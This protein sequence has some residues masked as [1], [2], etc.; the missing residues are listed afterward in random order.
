MSTSA[1]ENPLTFRLYQSVKFNRPIDKEKDFISPGGYELKMKD[2]DGTEKTVQFDFEDF[3][4]GVN[5]NDPCVL[6]C[7]QKNPDYNTFP[8]LKT[9]TKHMLQNVTE[10]VEWFIYTGEPEDT[11]LLI[12]VEVTDAS[13]VIIGENMKQIPISVEIKPSCG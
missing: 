3:E 9:V 5:E 11:D 13:F 6:D 10:V 7:M 1:T 12:P 2:K 8:D 4:G